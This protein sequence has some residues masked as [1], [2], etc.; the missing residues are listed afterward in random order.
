MRPLRPR[1]NRSPSYRRRGIAGSALP[2]EATGWSR[3]REGLGDLQLGATVGGD[4]VI[5]VV[6]QR[7]RT[8]KALTDGPQRV[9]RLDDVHVR[10]RGRAC[11]ANRGGG[12]RSTPTIRH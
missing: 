11:V 5:D 9:A 12:G 2:P 3:K 8:V 4:Q 7:G 6:S 10:G 1:A